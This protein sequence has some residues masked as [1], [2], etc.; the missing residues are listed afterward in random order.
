MAS[1]APAIMTASVASATHSI[2]VGAGGVML[3]NH[4]PLVVAE[5]FGT[6]SSLFPG[7]I[8]LAVGRAVGS[9]KPKE[10]ITRKALGRKPEEGEEEF[11]ERV[12][13]LTGYLGPRQQAGPV[14]AGP[15]Q[16]SDVELFL[17]SSSGRNAKLAAQMGLPLAFAAHVSKKNLLPSLEIYRN[18]FRPSAGLGKPYVILSVFALAAEHD[19][20][21]RFLFSSMEQ[22]MVG[23]IRSSSAKLVAPVKNMSEIWTPEEEKVIGQTVSIVGGKTSVRNAIAQLVERTGADE[24]M[25][26]CDCYEYSD[27]VRSHAI[28][29]DVT[30]FALNT[31]H[32]DEHYRP[33]TSENPPGQR[34]PGPF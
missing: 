17:L 15:G 8:D 28:L 6:L 24:L 3:L 21:A 16:N 18:H 1:V 23:S 32:T 22:M 12:R 30:L 34:T 19:E 14:D 5:Q 25:F 33:P 9:E 29:A 10:T 26:I 20:Q 7:R 2:R 4:S 11:E 31:A 27:R 13:E